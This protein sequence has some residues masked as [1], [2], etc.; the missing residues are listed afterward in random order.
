MKAGN[1]INELTIFQKAN[2]FFT[3]NIGDGVSSFIAD[4]VSLL[5]AQIPKKS[6]SSRTF[7]ITLVSGQR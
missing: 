1:Q 6:H 7:Y 5:G 4:E 3:I 2:C